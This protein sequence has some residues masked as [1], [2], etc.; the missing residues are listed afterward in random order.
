MPTAETAPR[1][2]PRGG[3]AI[4]DLCGA[5]ASNRRSAT[6]DSGSPS[7]ARATAKPVRWATASAPAPPMHRNAPTG[8]CRHA[9]RQANGEIR[10]PVS[11]SAAP[12]IAQGRAYRA[13]HSARATGSKRARLMG[14][15]EPP[16]RALGSFAPV[17]SAPA[18]ARRPRSSA[19]ATGF[20]RATPWANGALRLRATTRRAA[21]GHAWVYA[22]R[23]RPSARATPCRPALARGHG[24]PAVRVPTC[25][26]AEAARVCACRAR[27]SARATGCRPAAAMGNG[28]AQWHASTRLALEGRARGC[29]LLGARNARAAAPRRHATRAV[30]GAIR[31]RARRTRARTE[32]VASRRRARSRAPATGRAARVSAKV[33]ATSAIASRPWTTATSGRDRAARAP[34]TPAVYATKRRPRDASYPSYVHQQYLHAESHLTNAAAARTIA[35]SI[36]HDRCGVEQNVAL[37]T[38]NGASRKENASR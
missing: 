25:A 32:G 8:V 18:R 3:R 12:A 5:R 14:N 22:L 10:S 33:R 11:T 28:E 13:P 2:R 38:T 24:G 29:A 1:K 34:A 37:S 7:A 16:R 31:S 35:T 17:G 21:R 26:P 9:V 36:A 23:V 4:P 6:R 20:R 30:H 27:S 15:G 19:R